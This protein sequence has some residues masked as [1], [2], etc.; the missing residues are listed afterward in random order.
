LE[1]Y[2]KLTEDERMRRL[3]EIEDIEE[4]IKEFPIIPCLKYD[5]TL[6]DF[7]ELGN[8]D[9]IA[10]VRYWHG[11]PG[12][13]EGIFFEIEPWGIAEIGYRV[14]AR[15]IAGLVNT[16]NY[17]IDMHR[18]QVEYIYFKCSSLEMPRPLFCYVEAQL[19]DFDEY[20]RQVKRGYVR[21]DLLDL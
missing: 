10:D 3:D 9:F 1:E 4:N 20:R 18:G 11:S 12:I 7:L 19:A 21:R 13:Q 16:I 14:R 2:I 15:S 17:I 5:T 6:R 8:E